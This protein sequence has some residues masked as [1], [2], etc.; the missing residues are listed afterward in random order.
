MTQIPPTDAPVDTLTPGEQ[1]IY[2][3]ILE[4]PLEASS[5]SIRQLADKASTST[6]SIL[7]LVRKFGFEGYSDFRYELQRNP[8]CGYVFFQDRREFELNSFFLITAQSE[9]FEDALSSAA[10]LISRK[11]T[12][13]FYGDSYGFCAC[14]A[15]IR[16]IQET[17]RSASCYDPGE[18]EIPYPT[19]SCAVVI[20][21]SSTQREMKQ[22]AKILPVGLIPIIAIRC[23][24]SPV[25]FPCAMIDCSYLKNGGNAASLIPAVHVLEQLGK[26]IKLPS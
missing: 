9:R 13:F 21:G 12:I 15:G 3:Y 4:N 17:G 24:G 18:T 22:M 10:A 8:E 11:S 25:S 5:M 20:T 26:K 7:R 2:Q 14:E 16:M 6:S 1:Y 23:G 19:R